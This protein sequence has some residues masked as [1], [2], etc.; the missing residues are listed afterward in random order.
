MDRTG[1]VVARWRKEVEPELS[2]SQVLDNYTYKFGGAWKLA[3]DPNRHL[4]AWVKEGTYKP[5]LREAMEKSMKN[6]RPLL[7]GIGSALIVAAIIYRWKI[8]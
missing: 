6:Y 4:R 8:K 7:I 1:A 5:E 3:G 2:D